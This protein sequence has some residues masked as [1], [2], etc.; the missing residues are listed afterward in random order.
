MEL[1]TEK[2]FEKMC[3]GCRQNY[4]RMGVLFPTRQSANRFL[5][6]LACEGGDF[7]EEHGIKRYVRD[8]GIE[9]KNGS[10]IRAVTPDPER[11]RGRRY[12]SVFFS[13]ECLDIMDDETMREFSIV[14]TGRPS[15]HWKTVAPSWCEEVSMCSTEDFGELESADL[16]FLFG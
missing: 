8:F 6:E 15:Q 1:L 9:F 13:G 12:E 14:E 10:W 5:Q 7:M 3:A 4:T 2:T 11:I 16:S